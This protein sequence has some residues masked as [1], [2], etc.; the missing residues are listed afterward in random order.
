[1]TWDEIDQG[2]DARDFTIRTLPS[3]LARAGDLWRPLLTSKGVDLR[4]FSA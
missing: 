2:F 1:L 3:R 4:K